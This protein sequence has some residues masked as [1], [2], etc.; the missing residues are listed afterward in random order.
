ML[1]VFRKAP[2]YCNRGLMVRMPKLLERVSWSVVT[3]GEKVGPQ[4]TLPDSR[5]Q[6]LT[7]EYQIYYQYYP[8]KSRRVS[9]LTDV[10]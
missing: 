10:P 7:K 5:Q 8:V 1:T 9:T 4:D 3:A 2:Y 6:R